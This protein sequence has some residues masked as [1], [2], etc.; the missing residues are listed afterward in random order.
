MREAWRQ[1]QA[2]I[3]YIYIYIYI[4]V[5]GSFGFGVWGGVFQDGTRRKKMDFE[6]MLF[7]AI[8]VVVQFGPMMRYDFLS[9]EP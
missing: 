7:W 8:L 2:K 9:M 5:G 6:P 4:Y 1:L 3:I